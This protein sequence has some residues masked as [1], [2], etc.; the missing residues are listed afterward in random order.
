[1]TRWERAEFDGCELVEADLYGADMPGCRFVRCDL[2]GAQV[3]KSNLSGTRFTQSRLDRIS[4]ADALQG[5][6]IGSD[7][8]VPVALAL[9][10]ARAIVVDD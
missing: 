9:F 3:S 10:T 8:I 4:G 5:I 2:S 1:M 6:T 7:Q